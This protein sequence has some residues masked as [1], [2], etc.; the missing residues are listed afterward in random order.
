MYCEL[1]EMSC[2]VIAF[3]IKYNEITLVSAKLILK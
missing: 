3:C 1:C 2:D